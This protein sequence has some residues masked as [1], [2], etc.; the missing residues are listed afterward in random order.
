MYFHLHTGTMN[1]CSIDKSTVEAARSIWLCQGCN[2]PKP[3]AQAIDVTIQGFEPDDPPLNFVYGFGIPLAH[4]DFLF[5]FGED[6]VVRDLFLGRVFLSNGKPLDDWVTFRGRYQ[7]IIRGTRNVSYR[8]CTECARYVYFAMGPRYLYPAPPVDAAMFESDL[9]GLIV[10][11]ELFDRV[12]LDRWEKLVCERLPVLTA[13]KDGL[14]Q[15]I[16]T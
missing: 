2:H 3:N 6:I 11:R 14:S 8:Q 5:S 15:L 16:P 12:V 4:K 1:P 10:S 9:S 7:L 13:P